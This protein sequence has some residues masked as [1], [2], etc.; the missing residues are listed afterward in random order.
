MALQ[1][2]SKE[3][4][5]LLS[6]GDR[7]LFFLLVAFLCFGVDE[8]FCQLGQ[9]LIGF[10]FFVEGL[11]QELSGFFL[12][13]T[14]RPGAD[15]SIARNFVMFDL[16]RGRNNAGLQDSVP[17]I[18]FHQLS[19]FFDQPLH[20]FAGFALGGLAERLEYLLEPGDLSFGDGKMSS[21]AER[22]SSEEAL[23]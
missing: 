15:G 6:A 22:S 12:P 16:L 18:F 7:S 20:R 2:V 9:L 5:R 19:R 4:E 23:I 13:A 14:F 11:L 10:G 1:N 8:V 3:I 17:G 21:R